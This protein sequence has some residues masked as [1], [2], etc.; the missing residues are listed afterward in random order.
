MLEIA[1]Q[2]TICLL[3]AALIGFIMGFIVG[4]IN[5]KNVQTKDSEIQPEAPIDNTSIEEEVE[6]LINNLEEKT[7]NKIDIPTTEATEK[8]TE[9]LATVEAEDEDEKPQLFTDAKAPKKDN[10]TQ[11]KGIGPKV[12]EQLNKTGIYTFEQIANWTEKNIKWLEKNTNFA[13]R[14]KKDLWIEQAKTFI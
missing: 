7:V 5:K 1:S 3:L 10:L 4:R 11:I 13:H 14:A 6:S 8:I 12:E 9:A 2:I